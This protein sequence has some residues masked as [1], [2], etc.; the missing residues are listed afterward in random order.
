MADDDKR[1]GMF[2]SFSLIFYKSVFSF[3]HKIVAIE[4]L[5]RLGPDI[6]DGTQLRDVGPF[7]GQVCHIKIP[8]KFI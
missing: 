6:L 7:R 3:Y 8:P 5:Y 4:H 2:S 1:L